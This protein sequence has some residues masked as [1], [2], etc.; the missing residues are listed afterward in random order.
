M[1]VGK[2]YSKMIGTQKLVETRK[3]ILMRWAQ[4]VESQLAKSAA[5]EEQISRFR[6]A[7]K[8]SGTGSSASDNVACR[9]AAA[10]IAFCWL[11]VDSRIGWKEGVVARRSRSC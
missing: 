9:V 10:C 5:K 6:T 1:A 11:P 2:K 3:S 7:G 8:W 4:Q